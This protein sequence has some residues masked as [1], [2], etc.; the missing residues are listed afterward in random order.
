MN[1]EVSSFPL[2]IWV[3][4]GIIL[5]IFIIYFMIRILKYINKKNKDQN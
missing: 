3:T 4:F 1:L 2:T 5:T